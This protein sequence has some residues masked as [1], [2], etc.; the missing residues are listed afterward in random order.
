MAREDVERKLSAIAATI[1]RLTLTEKR[2][3]ITV[4]LS[5]GTD[6]IDYRFYAQMPSWHGVLVIFDEDRRPIIVAEKDRVGALKELL[7]YVE[8]DFE[9]LEIVD[10]EVESV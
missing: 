9:D 3:R 4:W 6:R 8:S 5:D 1:A 10:I 2:V 7:S